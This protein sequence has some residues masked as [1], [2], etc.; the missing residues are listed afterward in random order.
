MPLALVFAGTFLV[1]FGV[2]LGVTTLV[3][4][5]RRRR[6]VATFERLM[7]TRATLYAQMN[8]LLGEFQNLS[9]LDLEARIASVAPDP[10]RSATGTLM[11]D[12]AERLSLAALDIDPENAP[13]PLRPS[14]LALEEAIRVL[15]QGLR[16]VLASQTPEEFVGR[17]SRAAPTVNRDQLKKADVELRAVA[18]AEDMLEEEHFYED[19]TFYV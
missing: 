9:T 18:E 12:V 19:S 2:I 17:L 5:V 14:A 15:L 8:A 11:F 1:A 4:A 10:Q 16:S 6:R 3:R 7:R 13:R